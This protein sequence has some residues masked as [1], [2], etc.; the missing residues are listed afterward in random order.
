MKKYLIDA[1]GAPAN[2]RTV[3]LILTEL[4]EGIEYANCDKIQAQCLLKFPAEYREVNKERV[5]WE[6][7]TRKLFTHWAD[8]QI[9]GERVQ[10]TPMEGTEKEGK[11]PEEAPKSPTKTKTSVHLIYIG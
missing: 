6:K 7:D 4:S 2:D 1:T 8:K 11:V 5:F 10:A 3:N 9:L